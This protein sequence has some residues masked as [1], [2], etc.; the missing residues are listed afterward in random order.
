MMVFTGKD[1]HHLPEGKSLIGVP[2][3]GRGYS[4]GHFLIYRP[5]VSHKHVKESACCI[6]DG[7]HLDGLKQLVVN[8]VSL[9]QITQLFDV[10]VIAIKCTSHTAEDWTLCKLAE[11]WTDVWQFIPSWQ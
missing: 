4:S 5:W 9:M 8:V 6:T 7:L 2:G 11:S 1:I 10:G 3:R